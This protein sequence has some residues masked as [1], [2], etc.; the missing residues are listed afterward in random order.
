M[1]ASAAASLVAHALA[2]LALFRWAPRQPVSGARPLEVAIELDTANEKTPPHQ[3][4]AIP[5]ETSVKHDAAATAGAR[6]RRSA[7]DAAAATRARPNTRAEPSAPIEASG[8]TLD[9]PAVPDRLSSFRPASRGLPGFAPTWDSP[10]FNPLDGHPAPRVGSRVS[11]APELGRHA[12]GESGI[13]ADV[14]DDG[15]IRFHDPSHRIGNVGNDGVPALGVPFDLTDTLMR[16]T[17]QDPYRYAK[18]KLADATREERL[19][20]ARE[21]QLGRSRVALLELKGQI[22]A[23]LAREDLDGAARRRALF[24]LWDDCREP[25]DDPGGV[26]AAARATIVAAIRRTFPKGSAAAY[27]ADELTAYNARRRSGPPF[28]PY[29]SP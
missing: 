6:R 21:E 4:T 13:T 24:E 5:G 27:S 25:D 17:G 1:H 14:S 28:D 18:A 26:A 16:A 8:P 3:P 11:P 12:Q 10:P 29:A 20:R 2:L 19:C 15:R 23:L 7:R 9:A 22:A